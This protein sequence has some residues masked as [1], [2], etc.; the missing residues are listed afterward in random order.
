MSR[1]LIHVT[2]QKA[3]FP[4]ALNGE[5]AINHSIHSFSIGYLVVVFQCLECTVRRIVVAKEV[6]H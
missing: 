2:L 5:I 3:G 6:T 1:K 4:V